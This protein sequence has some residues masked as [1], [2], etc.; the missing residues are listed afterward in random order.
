MLPPDMGIAG[1]LLLTFRTLQAGSYA[2]QSVTAPQLIVA[3]DAVTFRNAWNIYVRQGEPPAIDFKKETAVFLF[4][5]RKNTGGYSIEVKSVKTSGK[6]IVIDAAIKPPP[7]DSFSTQ[8][9]TSP[10]V[11]IAI[12]KPNMTAVHWVD[13]KKAIK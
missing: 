11:V 4:A 3:R 8:A 1:L 9:L 12:E 5:G 7:P 6:Q 10:F 2:S 13:G